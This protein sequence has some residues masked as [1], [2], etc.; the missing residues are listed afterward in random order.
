[1]KI[2]SIRFIPGKD[3]SLSMLREVLKE[4]SCS[5]AYWCIYFRM[6]L[7]T[8]QQASVSKP[9]KFGNKSKDTNDDIS[10][11]FKTTCLEMPYKTKFF[12]T[13]KCE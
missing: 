4:V 8:N 5:C 3:D 2:L 10:G 1:M 12:K 6:V 9:I 11:S 13:D 7:E